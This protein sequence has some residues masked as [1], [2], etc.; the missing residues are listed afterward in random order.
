MRNGLP[1]LPTKVVQDLLSEQ[2]ALLQSQPS[3][4][5]LCVEDLQP[6]AV[7]IVIFF[8]STMSD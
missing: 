1:K 7:N 3:Q 2:N 4:N 5:S 6:E 8:F